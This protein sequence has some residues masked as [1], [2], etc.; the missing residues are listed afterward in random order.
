MYRKSTTRAPQLYLP[1]E[2]S[3]TQ[4]FYALKNPSTPA[5]IEPTNFGSRGEYDNHWTTG[6]D[7]TNCDTRSF[8]NFDALQ[9]PNRAFPDRGSFL[10]NDQFSVLR[11]IQ[12][13][14]DFL[15][16]PV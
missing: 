15:G 10:N 3:H 9:H 1:C 7:G 16:H 6:V 2:G 11:N 13:V 5:G 12:S 8:S 4:D 14:V